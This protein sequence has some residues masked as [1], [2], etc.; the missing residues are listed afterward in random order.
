M[1][2][3]RTGARRRLGSLPRLARARV[4]DWGADTDDA[5]MIGPPQGTFPHFIAELGDA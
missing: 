3:G 1:L 2:S 4:P 5:A